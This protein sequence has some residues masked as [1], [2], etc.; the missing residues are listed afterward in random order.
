MWQRRITQ[1]RFGV[2]T[3]QEEETATTQG[4]QLDDFKG[5]AELC[6]FHV[7]FSGAWHEKH[8]LYLSAGGQILHGNQTSGGRSSVISHSSNQSERAQVQ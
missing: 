4:P 5:L 7:L 3:T 1:C 6:L 2:F 8:P